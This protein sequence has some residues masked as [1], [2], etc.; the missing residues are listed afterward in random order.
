M[1][2]RVHQ[3]FIHDPMWLLQMFMIKCVVVVDGESTTG[4]SHLPCLNFRLSGI[5]AAALPERNLKPI[6]LI[7][8]E[9]TRVLGA[10][11]MASVYVFKEQW[12]RCS[13]MRLTAGIL[14]H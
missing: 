2:P 8:G 14:R 11:G 7:D 4:E 13:V 6:Q 1:R 12:V 5:M 9:A 3:A 10:F